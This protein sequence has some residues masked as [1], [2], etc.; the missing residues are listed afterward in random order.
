LAGNTKRAKVEYELARQ[1]A[2]TA[3]ATW[4]DA[5]AMLYQ[6]AVGYE[7]I[8]GV[9]TAQ[10]DL[11]G[12]LKS[13]QAALDIAQKLAAAD[14]SNAQWQRDLSISYNKIGGVQTAQG[15]LAGALKSFQAAL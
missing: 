14:P 12:A 11:A 6:R 2:E 4:P 7:R 1:S 13:F 10:G 8:G 3:S 15:D 5:V 9:Q